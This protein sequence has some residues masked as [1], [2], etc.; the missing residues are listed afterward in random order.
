MELIHKN[1]INIVQ[2]LWNKKKIIDDDANQN[3][4]L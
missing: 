2:F 1:N 4:N 3:Y